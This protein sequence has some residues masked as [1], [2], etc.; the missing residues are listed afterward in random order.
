MSIGSQTSAP[1]SQLA[2]LLASRAGVSSRFEKFLAATRETEGWFSNQSAAIWDSLLAFQSD[3]GLRGDLMEIGVWAG[4]SASLLAKNAS[5]GE[6][7]LLVDCEMRTEQISDT[8]RRV[9]A[10]DE[11]AIDALEED[12]A[13]LWL[14]PLMQERY[15]RH[16]WFHIDGEHTA[17][18]VRNDL[19]LAN[20]LVG[21]EGLVAVDD[22]FSWLYPQITESVLR[23]VREFPDQF[24]LFLCGYNKAY[25]AR[26]HFVHRYLEFCQERLPAEMELRGQETTVAHT[27]LPGEMNTFGIG[28][29][30]QGLQL[31]GPD[32]APNEVLR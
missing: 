25:L 32:W 8:L 3:L 14:H 2:D 12:S 16:R 11:V 24:S 28:P 18:A 20:K 19:E 10:S 7:V 5:K 15:R 31:R 21:K 29:R 1:T 26:P 17:G 27:T 6:R 9:Q 23:Y 22:F 4:K 13:E 30:F